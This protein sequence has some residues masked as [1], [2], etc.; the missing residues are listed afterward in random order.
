MPEP[1]V[2]QTLTHCPYCALNCGLKLNT[3]GGEVVG[4]ERWK[5]SPFSGGALCSK[6]VTAWQ[7]VHHRDRLLRPL[8]RRDGQLVETTWEHA[9]DLAAAGFADV[10]RRLGPAGNAVMGGGSLTNEKAYLVGK[11]ARLALRTPHVDLNGRM[12]MSSAAA[13]ATRAFGLDRAM[14]P[15]DDLPHAQVAMVIGANISS[16]Y[17]VKVPGML[18]KVRRH[19]RVIVVDP[20][21][22][23]FV[24]ATD[25]HLALKPGTDAIIAN[26]LLRAVAA[27]GLVDRRFV[28]ER[29]AGFD[30]ALAAA[31]PWTPHRVEAATGVDAR[32][33][34]EAA[35]LLGSA[36]R[37]MVL[38]ARGAEQ[39]TS[40][41]Q[42][43]L[44]YI[45]VAL[46][47]GLAGR[48]GCGIVPL[49]GQRNGQGGREHGQRCDQL[50][51]ARSI[52]D[53]EHRRQV[54]ATWGVEPER[55][56]GRG[57]SFV[58]VFDD[59]H[60]GRV[61]G[62]LTISTNPAVS[63]P[64][65]HK[66]RRALSRLEHLVVID[67]FLSE[68]AQFATVVLP[69]TTFAE[70]D[71]TITTTDGRVVRV[72]AAVGPQPGRGDIDVFRNLANRLGAGRHFSFVDGRE[73]FEELRRV[74]AGG[75]ADY[76]GMTWDAIR[77][78]GGI[79]WPCPEEGHPGTPLLYTERFAHPDGKA[80]FHAVT[81]ADPPVVADTEYPLVLTT[82]RV[83]AHYL[84][85]NQTRRIEDQAAKAPEAYV[86][87]H[88][89]TASRL[90]L[91]A[92]RPVRLTSRQGSVEVPWKDHGGLRRDMLFMPYHWPVANLL[93]ADDLDPVSR[94]PGLKYT[95]VKLQPAPAPGDA[96]EG[97]PSTPASTTPSAAATLTAP[98]STFTG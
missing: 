42:N 43:A 24:A 69:G 85:G 59:A 8:V 97:Q 16:T 47:C 7:Q 92:G 67:P 66:V 91:Q 65:L 55:I 20:R 18:D 15:L 70:E 61:A 27:L 95:P 62:M 53:P 28:D 26:G 11:F 93:T 83:L 84:S 87:V 89:A 30:E 19:G 25:L 60:E 21:A 37:A 35:R 52:E 86:E 5:Q 90:G 33:L 94:I 38:H 46:A 56:P 50:P 57:R 77:S 58:E 2:E 9:L 63:S 68:T 48:R 76:S 1:V 49:T 73:V 36:K 4:Y 51:G 6:G 31:E 41:T 40:G 74:S 80:R 12:C 72:D 32:S 75:P 23:R 17:P 98:S 10:R 45:N 22:G 78:R 13:A 34:V 88:P 81:P 82:G 96:T 71:G 44:A 29:T 39:Q 3:T 54:A 14:T 79:F 64:D